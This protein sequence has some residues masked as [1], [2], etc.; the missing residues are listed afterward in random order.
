MFSITFTICATA[1]V[2]DI[3]LVRYTFHCGF[4][5]FIDLSDLVHIRLEPQ[6]GLEVLSNFPQVFLDFAYFWRSPKRLSATQFSAVSS[7]CISASSTSVSDISWLAVLLTSVSLYKSKTGTSSWSR[8]SW[9]IQQ[10]IQLYD[11]HYS[12]FHSAPTKFYSA[13]T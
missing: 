10:H 3:F 13:P 9:V 11:S 7:I 12:T 5:L 6:V 8:K 2:A 1:C 4:F